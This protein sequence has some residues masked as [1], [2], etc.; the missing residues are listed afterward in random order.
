[1][2]NNEAAAR[3]SYEE[4]D[5]AQ[6]EEELYIL[7]SQLPEGFLLAVGEDP[8]EINS[9]EIEPELSSTIVRYLESL[10]VEVARFEVQKLPP[11]AQLVVK[12]S[13]SDN[14]AEA[15]NDLAEVVS[16]SSRT[17]KTRKAE[18]PDEEDHVT[19]PSMDPLKL[20]LREI[21]KVELLTASKEIELA[22][23]IERGDLAAKNHMIEAN[24]RL[25]VSISKRYRNQG[26]SYLELI[27]EGNLGLVRAV[28]KFDWR[29]GYKFSTYATWW[30]RQ[31]L[32]RALADK[33]RTIRVPVHKV[34]KLNKLHK[35]ER[36]LVQVIGAEPTSEELAQELGWDLNEVIE[37]ESI[38]KVQPTSLDVHI[39]EDGEAELG[40][41]IKDERSP[42]P[43]DE[44]TETL[45][46]EDLAAALA[47]L[48][49]RERQILELRYGLNGKEPLTLDEIGREFGITRERVRQIE[50]QTI[51]KLESTKEAQSL[52]NLA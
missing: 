19:N 32:Q 30:V 24:L 49:D 22:K 25:V 31:A 39:G 29:R 43:Y 52:R 17:S 40:N 42:S 18:N 6:A 2:S 12:K 47:T 36:N 41:F 7:L 26:L 46:N 8:D 37:V 33:S 16:I 11:E 28:E 44:L 34:E 50:K 38:A 20:Y 9:L 48:E 13:I 10:D 23:R 5:I 51:K 4:N 15:E 14:T 1:M 21:G 27:Q 45:M 3:I 35:A